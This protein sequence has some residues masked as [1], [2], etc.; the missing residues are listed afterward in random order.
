MYRDSDL[1]EGDAATEETALAVEGIPVTI[2]ENWFLDFPGSRKEVGLYYVGFPNGKA[3]TQ[4]LGTLYFSDDFSEFVIWFNSD[5]LN[6]TEYGK[7]ACYPAQTREEAV[8]IANRVMKQRGFE[9]A[10]WE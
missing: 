7:Y 9:R 6:A 4:R 2:P 3:T 5:Y 1:T 8:I 10:I